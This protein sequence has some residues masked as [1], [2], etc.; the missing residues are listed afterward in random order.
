VIDYLIGI[1]VG[2]PGLCVMLLLIVVALM[3]T[4]E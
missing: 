2:D 3:G 4:A 1:F